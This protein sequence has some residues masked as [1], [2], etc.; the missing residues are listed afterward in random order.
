MHSPHN[1]NTEGVAE[2]DKDLHL[3]PP[4]FGHPTDHPRFAHPTAAP[5]RSRPYA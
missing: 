1:I 3:T 2:L 5:A 4:A